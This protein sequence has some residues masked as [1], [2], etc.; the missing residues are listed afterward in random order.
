MILGLRLAFGALDAEPREILAQPRQRPLVQ[1][2]GEIV[3]AVGQQLAAPEPDEEI[4]IL[5]L[6]ALGIGAAARPRRARHAPARA[7]S[8][9]RASVREPLEQRGVR[10]AREQRREQR[11]FLRARGIDLVDVAAV[12]WCSP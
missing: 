2:A 3:R 1:E 11:I 7:G 5:A 12:P 9:R 6:D 10:R 8:H 4:E